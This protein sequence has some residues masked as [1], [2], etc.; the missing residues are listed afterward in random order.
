M[1]LVREGSL[2]GSNAAAAAGTNQKKKNRD[3]HGVGMHR[4]KTRL[5]LFVTAA[6]MF[7]LSLIFYACCV[8]KKIGTIDCF[9]LMKLIRMLQF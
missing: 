9:F 2:A 6:C 5:S 7:F 3:A 8:W 4:D 1:I